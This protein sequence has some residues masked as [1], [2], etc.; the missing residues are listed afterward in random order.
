VV[1]LREVALSDRPGTA[2]RRHPAPGE[3]RPAVT[4]LQL[5]ELSCPFRMVDQPVS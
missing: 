2:T 4:V 3:R 1:D 5:F